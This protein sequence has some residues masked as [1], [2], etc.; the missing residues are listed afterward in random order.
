MRRSKL[1][2]RDCRLNCANNSS[3][4]ETRAHLRV[5]V[6]DFVSFVEDRIMPIDGEKS[7]AVVYVRRV[8]CDEDRAI[9]AVVAP[10]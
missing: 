7:F 1:F 3:E 2:E 8:G 5:W 9:S 10:H 4:E 6:S